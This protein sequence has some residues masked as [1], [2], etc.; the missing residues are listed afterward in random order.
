MYYGRNLASDLASF[1]YPT[2]RVI[3]TS[4]DTA[5]RISQVQ[6]VYNGVASTHA[7]SIN[8]W[9][10]RV[11]ENMNIG[12]QNSDNVN[13]V[14]NTTLN[15]RLQISARN[16]QFGSTFPVQFSFTY[17]ATGQNNGNLTTQQ[18][19][20]IAA[21]NPPCVGAPPCTMT[22]IPA[23]N[24]TQNYTYDAYDR[25]L[26]ATEPG[27]TSEST[28]NYLYDQ[29]GNRAVQTG[30]FIPNP[31]GT[32]T[33]LTQFTNNQWLGTG[34]SYDAAG[35]A[36]GVPGSTN[37]TFTYDAENRVNTANA[38]GTITYIY[39]GQGRRVEKASSTFSTIY[40]YDA[41]GKAI[42]ETTVPVTG[43]SFPTDAPVAGTEYLIEDHLGSTRLSM[44]NQGQVV[45]RYDFLPF[46]EEI[47]A[48][49]GGRGADYEPSNYVYPTTP[50]DVLHKFTSKE[51]DSETGLDFFGARYF[52]SAEGR[53]VS[54]DWSAKPEPVPYAN[55]EDPQTLN[56]YGYIRNNPMAT[57][58][59]DGHCPICA[60][61]G[62]VVE[63]AVVGA[64]IG[65]GA[66]VAITAIAN[67]NATR[68]NYIGAAASGA[69]AGGVAGAT[70][71]ASLGAQVVLNAG[72]NV[73]GGIVE[74]SNAAQHLD[75][76]SPNELLKDAAIGGAGPLLSSAGG[77]LARA[78]N[79]KSA[80]ALEKATEG[81]HLGARHR[82]SLRAQ[83]AAASAVDESGRKAGDTTAKVI[84]GANRANDNAKKDK[85]NP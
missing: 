63:R 49:V 64:V 19:Q 17:G 78:I 72:A 48:G 39:D 85:K 79:G 33:A 8:Y 6:D 61:V 38:N 37:E 43:T 80:E 5:N 51:R 55:L 83:A 67:P 71:G 9:P 40:L 77:R 58:D 52:S 56:L 65:A 30:S 23:V 70:G 21:P 47:V 74:R 46:G 7:G 15:S 81:S 16:A 53:F 36:T 13:L 11:I 18:I 25:I 44:N 82:A 59:A 4:Y 20:T 3:L 31:N 57:M 14:E 45:R 54:A 34:A 62:Q 26:S 68:S 73:L 50:D 41:A 24:L 32:P 76:G 28:Q 66:A 60:L 35:D 2:G 29:W 84:D 1:I 42:V 22:P 27:G 10:N 69:I 75:L 12:H